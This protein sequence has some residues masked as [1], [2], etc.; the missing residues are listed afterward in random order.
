MYFSFS[1]DFREARSLYSR[2]ELNKYLEIDETIWYWLITF[3]WA[4][5]EYKE[6]QKEKVSDLDLNIK[7]LV[8]KDC[9]QETKKSTQLVV[10]FL[11]FIIKIIF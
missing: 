9:L 7:D 4:K 2:K 11:F 5:G 6:K 10:L 3:G 1:G 8:F